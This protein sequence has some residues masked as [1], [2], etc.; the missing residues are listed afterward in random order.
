MKIS[1]NWVKEYAQVDLSIDELVEKIGAQLGA[2]EEVIDLG[3]KYQGI[4]IAKVVKCEKHPNADKLSVCLIDDGGITP[5]VKRDANGYVEVVCGAPNVRE[6]QTVAWLPP[7]TTV[8]STVDKEPFVLEARELRGVVSNGMIASAAELAISDDHT[9]IVILDDELKPG[10]S[11]VEAFKLND[12][13]IDV[14]N[15]MF[16][17]RPDCFGILGVAR[18]VAGIQHLA[19]KSPDWYF[20][21]PS[22]SSGEGLALKVVNELPKQVPRFMAVAMKDVQVGP[23]PVWLQADLTKVGLKPINNIVDI[24][25]YLMYL[26]AQ[27]LHAYD[28]DKVAA[29]SGEGA[30]I[31]TRFPQKDEKVALLNGKTIEPGAETIMIA[32]DKELIGVGGVMGGTDTEV[33]E[34]TKNIIIECANFDMYTI[35]RAAMSQGLFTDAVTRFNK[36]QSPLQNDRVMAKAIEMVTQL[37]GGKQASA[38]IDDQHE[39]PKPSEIEITS[40]FINERLGLNLSVEEIANLLTN[41]EF[42]VVT[43]ED[44]SL[45][46]APFWRTD[47]E[48][49]EDIVEE[50]GRLYGFDHLPLDLPNGSIKPA[51]RDALLELKANIRHILSTSGANEVLTYS[52]VHGNLLDKVGQ[53]KEKAFKLTNALSPDLQYYRLSLTPSLLEKIHPNIKSGY[54][55]FA[56]FE[57]GNAHIKGL[58]DEQEPAIPAEEQRV[59]LVCASDEKNWKQNHAGAVYYQALH[60]ASTLLEGLNIDVTL[61]PG[62][63]HEPQS[64]EAKQCW[65]PFERSRTAY[66]RTRDGEPLGMV[67]EYTASVRRALKLPPHAAGFELNTSQLLKFTRNNPYS[68]LSRFPKVEQDLSLKVPSN[69]NYGEIVDFVVETA[70]K[71]KPENTYITTEALDI[72][73]RENDKEHRQ[74]TL[75]FTITSYERTMTAEEVNTLL[76]T[77]AAAAKEKFGAERL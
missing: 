63:K 1:L 50:V 56:L 33:D 31:A 72:F 64:D 32:T 5:S 69:L 55:Q 47:I 46:T 24:T 43:K 14:E 66:L 38:V 45:V 12:Y 13:I 25:N 77:A 73:Q 2:V 54:S 10:T 51:Q 29:R 27:P 22:F 6:G 26:T 62:D 60:Y 34:N 68:P 74:I 18:E 48:I 17:H 65:A 71:A 23:S 76:D 42:A 59:A 20:N 61:T 9:G 4:V 57:I 3:K 49:A 7:G 11:F 16:T 8:P 58:Q 36:G 21:Q 39:L 41:V 35:R 67:G 75:R 52:F 40:Q 30:I 44:Q 70:A 15:K 19:F 53:D 37:T 28:Y